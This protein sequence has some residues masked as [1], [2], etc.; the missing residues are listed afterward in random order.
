MRLGWWVWPFS[1]PLRCMHASLHSWGKTMRLKYFNTRLA[2]LPLYGQM[3]RVTSVD[4][5][6]WC[7]SSLSLADTSR[8][9][10]HLRGGGDDWSPS[11]CYPSNLF[12]HIKQNEVGLSGTHNSPLITV[13]VYLSVLREEWRI[14][15]RWQMEEQR[16]YLL[17][18]ATLF[19]D[20]IVCS[21]IG[22]LTLLWRTLG[23]VRRASSMFVLGTS[24][25][26]DLFIYFIWLLFY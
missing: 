13:I 1:G 3:A 16:C 19:S 26:V 22:R 18:L 25:G 20:Y 10:S 2:A 12:V 4:G 6:Y 21:G 15:I 17:Y 24:G 7:I 23:F 9:I 11:I 14:F 8:G 5:Y